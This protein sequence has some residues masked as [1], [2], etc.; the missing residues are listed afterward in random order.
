MCEMTP[1]VINGIFVL[2]SVVIGGGIAY[3]SA[4]A[5]SKRTVRERAITNLRAAFAPYIARARL[6]TDHSAERI[7]EIIAPRFDHITIEMEKLR[8]YIS[9]D[10]LPAYDEACQEYQ[11]ISRIRA[12]NYFNNFKGRRPFEV[13]EDTVD[14]IFQFT[15]P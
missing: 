13:L 9:D 1:T 3:F 12:M 14:S 4:L 10:N 5:S 8:L 2:V 7:R 11:N 15:N 6:D